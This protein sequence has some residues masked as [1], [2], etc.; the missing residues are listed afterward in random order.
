MSDTKQYLSKL[1]ANPEMKIDPEWV[2]CIAEKHPYF[3]LPAELELERNADSMT[4]ERHKVLVGRIALNCGTHNALFRLIEPDNSRFEN[5]YPNEETPSRP[6]TDNA[7]ATFIDNY[8]TIDPHEEEILTKLIFNP[9]PD[10]AQLLAQEEERS[11]P[12]TEEAEN[13][14]QDELINAFIIKSREN[15]G[16]F[17]SSETAAAHEAQPQTDES[18]VQ[19]PEV[20]DDSLLSESL[21]KIYI[22]QGRYAKAFEIISNLSLKY[23]EKSVYFADQ[24]RFLQKLIINQ[25]YK[26]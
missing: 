21:A 23:P 6:T 13:G 4:Q 7:I 9:T 24:M 14:S 2:D 11:M 26:S 1:L 20:Q 15:Y 25:Q 16:H 22:K 8:G 10:Y 5:F 19:V 12:T 3:T 17:P 18:P